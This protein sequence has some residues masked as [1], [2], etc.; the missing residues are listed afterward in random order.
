MTATNT[1]HKAGLPLRRKPPDRIDAMFAAAI[2]TPETRADLNPP[3]PPIAVAAPPPRVLVLSETQGLF[4]GIL[5][6]RENRSVTLS[7]C[8][9]LRAAG[10]VDIQYILYDGRLRYWCSAYAK[11]PHQEVTL[12]DATVVIPAPE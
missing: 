2:S 9:R 6:S 12:L 7:P 8:R 5:A 3:P 4:L 1:R 11:L 10:D